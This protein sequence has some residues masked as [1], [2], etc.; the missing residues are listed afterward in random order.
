MSLVSV[1]RCPQSL[2]LCRCRTTETEKT[3]A[4]DST[5]AQISKALFSRLLFAFDARNCATVPPTPATVAS[6]SGSGA[7]QPVGAQRQVNCLAGVFDESANAA[8]AWLMGASTHITELPRLVDAVASVGGPAVFLPLL[9]L[10]DVADHSKATGPS[11]AR[12]ESSGSLFGATPMVNSTS[13]NNQED[14]SLQDVD[15]VPALCE[16][17]LDPPCFS[18]VPCC[19]SDDILP[20]HCCSL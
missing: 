5:D 12:Q 16:L 2:C 19:V 13:S 18:L 15:R 9:R 1:H 3:A 8:V 7:S 14:D 20:P 4:A 10:S 6:A 11:L 17:K